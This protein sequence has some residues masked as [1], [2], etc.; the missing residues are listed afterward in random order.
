[1][2]SAA[3]SGDS[4]RT[5]GRSRGAEAPQPKLSFVTG[6]APW[7]WVI[8]TGVY[9]RRSP[10]PDLEAAA[11]PWVLAAIMLLFTARRLH[12]GG[13]AHVAAITTARV[14]A[15]DW[16]AVRARHRAGAD[17]ARRRDGRHGTGVGCSKSSPRQSP[18]SPSSRGRG[19]A[20]PRRGAPSEEAA[21]AERQSHAGGPGTANREAMP[22]VM[23][24]SSRGQSRHHRH[25]L[26]VRDGWRRPPAR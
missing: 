26:V 12:R 5:N 19:N 9:V 13:A 23:A 17:R 25:R 2:W 8:G 6:F 10:T 24:R 3:G 18:L 7:G 4:S 16:P 1:M 21:A 22:R 15:R 14:M 11:R 20:P